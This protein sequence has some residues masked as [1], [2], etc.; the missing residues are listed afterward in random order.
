MNLFQLHE[1]ITEGLF[2]AY[3]KDDQRFLALA[4]CG[5]A[6]ELANMVK[7]EWRDGVDLREEI[8]EEICDIRVYLELLAKC[9]DMEGPKLDEAVLKKLEKVV[10]KHKHKLGHLGDAPSQIK[11]R[12][13]YDPIL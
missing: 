8:K 3:L 10:E 9:F 11:E 7:K 2:P 6:G 5:E 4:I 1:K 12:V 13:W